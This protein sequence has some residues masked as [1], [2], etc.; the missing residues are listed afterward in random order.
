MNKIEQLQKELDDKT[1]A[2]LQAAIDTLDERIDKI[3]NQRIED[4]VGA[5]LGFEFRWGRAEIDHCNGRKTAIANQIGELALKKINAHFD[6]WIEKA[7]G[8]KAL[9]KG[10]DGGIRKEYDE[11]MQR[12]LKDKMQMHI[13][14]LIEKNGA[15]LLE[16]AL[17]RRPAKAAT[18]KGEINNYEPIPM[19]DGIRED[20]E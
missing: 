2:A 17:K 18:I 6:N 10:W 1:A 8:K 4:I 16:E 11:R 5:S 7:V 20:D 9:P 15:T 3:V 19:P 12:S 14:E 13:D